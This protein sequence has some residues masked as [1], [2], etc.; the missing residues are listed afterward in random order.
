MPSVQGL[1]AI[2][3]GPQASDQ[4]LIARSGVAYNMPIG[5]LGFQQFASVAA[6]RKNTGVTPAFRLM[7]YNEIGDGAQGDFVYN[8]LDTTSTDDGGMV[9]VDSAG[10]RYYRETDTGTA[11]ILWFG[12]VSDCQVVATNISIGIGSTTLT[13]SVAVFVPG[14]V[15]KSINVTRTDVLG[16]NPWW[17]PNGNTAFP[18]ITAYISATQVQVSIAGGALPSSTNS[19]SWPYNNTPC[20][21]MWGTNNAPAIQKALASHSAVF[22][23]DGNFGVASQIILKSGNTLFGHKSTSKIFAIGV[24]DDTTGNANPGPLF[25]NTYYGS[26]SSLNIPYGGVPAWTLEYGDN[27]IIIDNLYVD[28]TQA[29]IGYG[30]QF[31]RMFCVSRGRYSNLTVVG[32]PLIGIEGPNLVGC[33]DWDVYGTLLVN[34]LNGFNPFCGCTNIR[35]F[36]NTQYAFPIPSTPT[37]ITGGGGICIGINSIGVQSGG[38]PTKN[39]RI[40]KNTVYLYGSQNSAYIMTGIYMFPDTGESYISD[41][42]ICENIV[43]CQGS[44]NLPILLVGGN[45][46]CN[47]NDNIIVGYDGS[48]GEPIKVE[49]QFAFVPPSTTPTSITT[50]S[51]SSSATV[52]WTAHGMVGY[53]LPYFPYYL[54]VNSGPA[55]GGTTL[56]GTYPV[57]AVNNAN[58]FTINLGANATSSATTA[59]GS[60]FASVIFGPIN[61][62]VARNKLRDCVSTTGSKAMIYC[63]G[64]GNIVKDNDVSYSLLSAAANYSCIVGVSPYSNG[65]IC[66]VLNNTG[67]TGIAALNEYWSGTNRVGYIAQFATVTPLILDADDT[68]LTLRTTAGILL[69]AGS[70]PAPL[71]AYEEGTW[72]PALQFGGSSA[73][74]TYTVQQGYYRRIGSMFFIQASLA[75]NSIGTATGIAT[76]GGCPGYANFGQSF[77][78]EVTGWAS[79]PGITEEPA[80]I[81]AGTIIYIRTASQIAQVALTNA[82]FEYQSILSFAGWYIGPST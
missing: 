62:T 54:T 33:N 24:T 18:T 60:G 25:V 64:A 48:G 71:N 21:M 81:M 56:N 29:G 15:G 39:V 2:P 61:C 49:G 38:Q 26:A 70:N 59:W 43:I 13:S 55:I 66:I 11:N 79:L 77:R 3:G 37:G 47:V 65:R 6:V 40:F 35:Y 19:A 76:V 7:G 5:D 4:V 78:H 52:N 53:A 63:E 51:G 41:S 31:G 69:K 36:E 28:L 80:I 23:P 68:T 16:W 14:D 30:G 75:I 8:A 17:G 58:A 34:V 82:N 72:T 1:P 46:N 9:L 10:H 12:A 22:V 74:I 50:I 27:N 67:P 73:G 20:N 57:I 44:G 42:E 45:L 32:N